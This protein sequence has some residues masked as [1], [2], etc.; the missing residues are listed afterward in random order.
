MNLDV[1]KQLADIFNNRGYSLYLVGGAVRDYLLGKDIFD[2]DIV[3]DALP[4]EIKDIF[5]NCDDSF[6]KYGS[7]TIKY[8]DYKLDITTLRKEE[9]EGTKRIPSKIQYTKSIEEDSL[10]RD[11]TI[12]ALYMDKDEK[13]Y[14]FHNGLDDLKNKLIKSINNPSIRFKEDPLRMIRAMRF[15]LALGFTLDEKIIEAFKEDKFAL[16]SLSQL[17]IYK[18]LNKIDKEKKSILESNLDRY[19]SYLKGNYKIDKNKVAIHYPINTIEDLIHLRE[20]ECSLVF[21]YEE[22]YHIANH[23]ENNIKIINSYEEYNQNKSQ[24]IISVILIDDFALEDKNNIF[25]KINYSKII[26]TS[27]NTLNKLVKR[28]LRGE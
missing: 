19:F 8:N 20:N 13:I 4:N 2:F 9:Y 16:N 1:F 11:F 10:R 23:Y 18:E 27:N 14:D 25:S 7:V 6:I 5:P 22:E 3:S 12:N 28:M 17:M 26:N 15:A 21:N 24:G